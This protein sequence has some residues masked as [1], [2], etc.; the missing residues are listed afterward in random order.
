MSIRKVGSMPE[1]FFGLFR[2]ITEQ[3]WARVLRARKLLA[4]RSPGAIV[5]LLVVR[6]LRLR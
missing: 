1:S 4:L 5:L 2:N 6:I 3:S